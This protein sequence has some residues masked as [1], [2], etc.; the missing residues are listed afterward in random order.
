M[1]Y[2][3][4]HFFLMEIAVRDR[5]WRDSEYEKCSFLSNIHYYQPVNQLYNS[6]LYLFRQNKNNNLH[7]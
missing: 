1:R 3:I 5:A 7:A 6:I 4:T 2:H